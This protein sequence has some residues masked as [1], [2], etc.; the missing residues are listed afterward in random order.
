M[1]DYIK[2]KDNSHK[3]VIVKR[4]KRTYHIVD[5]RRTYVSQVKK[6]SSQFRGIA[7]FL[8]LCDSA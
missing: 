2:G 4:I 1:T 8:F 3:N 5:C 7:V 6:K